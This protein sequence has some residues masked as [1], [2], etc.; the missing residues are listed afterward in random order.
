MNLNLTYKGNIIAE[1]VPET[2][3]TKT[4]ELKGILI[5]TD[6]YHKLRSSI[7]KYNE[8]FNQ[9]KSE[10]IIDKTLDKLLQNKYKDLSKMFS[11]LSIELNKS[12]ITNDK[13]EIR[14]TDTLTDSGLGNPVIYIETWNLNSEAIDKDFETYEITYV[15]PSS[16]KDILEIK[17]KG[18]EIREY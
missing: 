15:Y 10:N 2:A 13:T 1:I 5:P 12:K 3:S 16:P 11:E 4:K 18:G 14:I 6:S 9:T 8:I 17:S 7:N